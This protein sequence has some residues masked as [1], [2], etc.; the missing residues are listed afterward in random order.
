[1]SRLVFRA[2]RIVAAYAACSMFKTRRGGHLGD[3]DCFVHQQV[4][5]ISSDKRSPRWPRKLG[6]VDVVGDEPV[7]PMAAARACSKPH[8]FGTPLALAL[9]HFPSKARPLPDPSPAGCT[10]NALAERPPSPPIPPRLKRPI[11]L[12]I[13]KRAKNAADQGKA[14][15]TCAVR[16]ELLATRPPL[17][18]QT[19]H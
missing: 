2:R 12:A 9:Q 4:P 18:P 8:W 1:M 15:S 14:Q 19:L 17:P 6:D 10:M 3:R 5:Q 16:S 13:Q 11:A 7:T